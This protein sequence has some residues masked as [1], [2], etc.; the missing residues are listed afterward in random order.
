MPCPA[1]L[2]NGRCDT[3][4]IDQSKALA[5]KLNGLSAEHAKK[6]AANTVCA[7]QAAPNPTN[8]TRTG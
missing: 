4:I 3:A 1:N 5:D 2:A 7:L 8:N 6:R